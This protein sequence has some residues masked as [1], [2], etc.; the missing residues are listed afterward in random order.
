MLRVVYGPTRVTPHFEA[1]IIVD[2]DRLFQPQLR[3]AGTDPRNTGS[4][5]WARHT[6]RPFV[7]F[8]DAVASIENDRSVL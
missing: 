7:S 4:G 1:R 5:R 3:Y 2:M 8:S 6:D